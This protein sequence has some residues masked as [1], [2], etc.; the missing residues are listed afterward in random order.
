MQ[1]VRTWAAGVPAGFAGKGEYT[2]IV[3]ESIPLSSIK[4]GY[5]GDAYDKIVFRTHSGTFWR[6]DRQGIH[7][8]KVGERAFER[9]GTTPRDSSVTVGAQFRFGNTSHT[10]VV[11][12]VLVTGGRVYSTEYVGSQQV[13]LDYEAHFPGRL[14]NLSQH[15]VTVAFPSHRGTRGAKAVGVTHATPGEKVSLELDPL[16][17]TFYVETESGNR[18]K[19]EPHAAQ[20]AITSLRESKAQGSPDTRVVDAPDSITVGEQ[21]RYGSRS[22]TSRVTAVL[23]VSAY[24]ARTAQELDRYGIIAEVKTS[25]ANQFEAEMAALNPLSKTPGINC[26][27]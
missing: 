16:A 17:A 19:I 3:G 23:S 4:G 14:P 11:T 6:I 24:E 21:F 15:G 10:G 27:I 22:R 18:Y 26:E 12:E 5:G 13:A 9:V 1:T 25:L 2:N 7:C 20:F 8:K